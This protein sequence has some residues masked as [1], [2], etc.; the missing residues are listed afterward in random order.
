MVSPGEVA[1]LSPPSDGAEASPIGE[2]RWPP[3]LALLA[4][5]TLNIALRVWLPSGATIRAPWLLPVIEVAL[6][7][8]LV[9]GHPGGLVVQRGRLRRLALVVVWI[10]VAAALWSTAVLV[11]DLI[12][13]TGVTQS[14][15]KLLA[16]GGLVWLGNNL[17]FA[18][19]YWLMDS[20]GPI[21]RV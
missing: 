16:S 8:L 20:G 18:L 13:A 15:T 17:A 6:I 2:S 12:K 19:L 21:A 7:L 4:F 11:Y 10:L 3:A 9:V 1:T 14:P 5:L